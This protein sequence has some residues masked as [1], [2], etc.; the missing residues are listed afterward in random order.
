[1]NIFGELLRSKA[2]GDYTF[3]WLRSV[4]LSAPHDIQLRNVKGKL[5]YLAVVE[6]MWGLVI[7]TTLLNQHDEFKNGGLN[8]NQSRQLQCGV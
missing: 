7:C 2:G 8:Y 1:M 4:P 5:L 6:T 3:C